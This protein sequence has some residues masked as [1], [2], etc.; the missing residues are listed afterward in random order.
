MQTQTSALTSHSRPQTSTRKHL[1][2]SFVSFP[3]ASLMLLYFYALTKKSS[4]PDASTQ[5][6]R[7]TKELRKPAEPSKKAQ[8]RRQVQLKLAARTARTAQTLLPPQNPAKGETPGQLNRRSQPLTTQTPKAAP[9]LMDSPASAQ[10]RRD[11]PS[12]K[13]AKQKPTCHR[14]GVVGHRVQTV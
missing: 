12:T 4:A 1:T 2:L 5:N 7:S 11:E 14:N 8:P 9:P 10:L 3:S 13:P 6:F